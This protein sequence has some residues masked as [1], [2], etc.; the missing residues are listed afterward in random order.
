M[1][2][3]QF[4]RFLKPWTQE[5]I[6]AG[7]A[8]AFNICSL[9]YSGVDRLLEV[10]RFAIDHAVYIIA[11]IFDDAHTFKFQIRLHGSYLL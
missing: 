5:M 6:P 9:P 7:I 8:Y 1:G 3:T 4:G 2:Q 11:H 10:G